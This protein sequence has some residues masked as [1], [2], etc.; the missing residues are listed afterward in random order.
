MC[1]AM[2]LVCGGCCGVVVV[3]GVV[4][5]VV[6]VGVAAVAATA[7][8]FGVGGRDSTT[9]HLGDLVGAHVS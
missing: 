5:G 7:Q 8:V 3:I 9:A 1:L 6:G 4:V 2:V